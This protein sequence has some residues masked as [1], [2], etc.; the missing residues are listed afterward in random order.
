MAI[1]NNSLSNSFIELIKLY[2]I[3]N[4]F[5]FVINFVKKFHFFKF[6]YK[7]VLLFFLKRIIIVT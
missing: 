7:N 2:K 5:L 6:S 3:T 4:K 1:V